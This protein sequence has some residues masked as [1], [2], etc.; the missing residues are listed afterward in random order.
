M[1]PGGGGPCIRGGGGPLGVGHIPGL[2]P[3]GL[4]KG[5]LSV[6]CSSGNGG[7]EPGL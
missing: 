3:P 4:L 7:R 1:G 5:G 6:A 2:S